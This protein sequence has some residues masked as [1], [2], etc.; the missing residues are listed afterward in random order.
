MSRLNWAVKK[1]IVGRV[2]RKRM[3]RKGAKRTKRTRE[4]RVK[5]RRHLAVFS[6]ESFRNHI[7]IIS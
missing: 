7:E 2:R 6:E 3:R 1:E 4:P 5:P